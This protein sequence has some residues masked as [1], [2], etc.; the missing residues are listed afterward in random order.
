MPDDFSGGDEQPRLIGDRI[1]FR[2]HAIRFQLIVTVWVSGN[3]VHLAFGDD[4][5]DSPGWPSY[6]Q[7]A[8][9]PSPCEKRKRAGRSVVA[10][11]VL[12]SKDTWLVATC[13]SPEPLAC[14]ACP[15]RVCWSEERSRS[16]CTSPA[17]LMLSNAVK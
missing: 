16:I 7:P 13:T 9:W 3:R 5:L 11:P 8:P 10:R 2:F 15:A 17:Q 4:R 14:S 6:R 1:E 12:W